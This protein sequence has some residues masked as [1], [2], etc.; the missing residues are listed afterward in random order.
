M[1]SKLCDLSPESRN[2]TVCVRVSRLWDYC[3]AR[4]GTAPF[5]VDLVLVD[6]EVCFLDYCYLF[7]TCVVPF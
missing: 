2:W 5:H 4:D 3:G 7:K 6:E 1:L